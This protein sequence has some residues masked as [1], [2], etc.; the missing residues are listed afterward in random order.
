MRPIAVGLTFRR[1]AAKVI[2]A[3]ASSR[4]QSLFAPVQL[5]V[6]VSRGLEAGVHA[7]RLFLDNLSTGHAVVKIDFANAFNSVRRDAVLEAVY[8][9]LPDAYSFVYSTYAHETKL[10]F[11]K[12]TISS[13]EGCSKV[14]RLGPLLFCLATLPLLSSC[15]TPLKFGYLD[16]FTLGG[17]DGSSSPDKLSNFELMLHNSVWSSMTQNVK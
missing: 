16:D 3:H 6:G 12:E 13:T 17:D 1:V 2:V 14:I 8:R 5:G 10:F 11:G 15:T 4:L 9:S 7:T